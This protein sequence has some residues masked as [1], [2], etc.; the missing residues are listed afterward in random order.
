MIFT[1]TPLSGAYVIELEPIADERGFFARSFCQNEFEEHGLTANFVQFNTSFNHKKATLRGMHYQASPDEETKLI[2][3]I[4]GSILD[5][6]VDMR[7]HSP[8]YRQWF[9]V[10]LTAENRKLLYCPEGCAHGYLTLEDNTELLYQVSRYY[11]PKS[12]RILRFDDPAIGI[13]W[14]MQPLVL[15]AKD[16]AA[17]HM[18]LA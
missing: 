16:A 10:E 1:T 2:R 5:V 15:S 9:G 6:I 11:A 18:V 4:H 13:E 12:E 3:C 7:T 8:T 17:P 14:P